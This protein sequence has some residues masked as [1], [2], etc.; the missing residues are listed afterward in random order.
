VLI[1]FSGLD[2]A[3][4]STLIEGLRG[5]LEKRDRR[6]TVFHM[7]DHIG[8]YAYARTVRDR[9]L[10]PNADIV[11]APPGVK[12]DP[13]E[14]RDQGT[15]LRRL[16]RR[17][18]DAVLWG[19]WLRRLIYPLD[20]VIFLLYRLHVE[21]RKNAVLVMDRYFYDTLVDVSDGRGWFWVR[22]LALITPTPTVPI[23]LDVTPEEAF[24]RK[25]EY[26]VDYLRRR[27]LAYR[28]IFPWVKNRVV[29]TTQQEVG[30]VVR[31]LEA[32]VAER[33]GGT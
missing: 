3:G 27:W 9:V 10:R 2:G 22:L 5:A 24:A 30:A 23:Y 19:K 15:G 26:S 29:L 13:P 33:M 32:V 8:L 21:R 4:K 7:N 28:H 31:Q 16:V 25:G 6:V 14:R 12:A 20:V 18:R 17:A 11:A 1:T